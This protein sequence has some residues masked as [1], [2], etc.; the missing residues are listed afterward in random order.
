MKRSTKHSYFRSFL[1]L[2]MIGVV[3]GCSSFAE[4][5][6][7]QPK[8][9]LD[10]VEVTN[11]STTGA[12]V[13]FKVR[14]ANPNGFALK[15]DSVKYNVEIG[16]NNLGDGTLDKGAKVEAHS[17]AVIPIPVPVK[18]TEVFSSVMSFLSE[19]KSKY[20]IRGDAAIGPLTIPFDKTGDLKI[21][22]PK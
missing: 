4:K 11:V 14:V 18:Y 17:E 21:E 19:G 8:V 15:V 6:V 1:I 10:K 12:T 2:I 3:S 16:G 13:L 20:R 22:K 9:G 5:I 7:E